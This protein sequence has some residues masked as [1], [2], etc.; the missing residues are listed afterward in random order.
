[1]KWIPVH[2]GRRISLL[3]WENRVKRRVIDPVAGHARVALNDI[4]FVP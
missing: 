2:A 3:A 1:M 4:R